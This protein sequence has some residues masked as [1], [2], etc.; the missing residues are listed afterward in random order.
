MEYGSF[1]SFDKKKSLK[2]EQQLMLSHF[3]LLW[4]YGILNEL[5]LHCKYTNFYYIIYKT[6]ENITIKVVIIYAAI[7]ACVNILLFHL[8]IPLVSPT[9]LSFRWH[10]PNLRIGATV[11]A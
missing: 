6:I 4:L 8:P 3:K 11:V 5:I 2:R 10:V 9:C 1:I 7:S